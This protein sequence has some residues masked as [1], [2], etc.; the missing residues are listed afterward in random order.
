MYASQ[1][2]HLPPELS[3]DLMVQLKGFGQLKNRSIAGK[4]IVY[5]ACEGLEMGKPC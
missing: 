4:I 2:F 5:P 1:S 3:V